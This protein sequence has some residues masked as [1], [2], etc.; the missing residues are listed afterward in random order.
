M[1][2]RF[3]AMLLGVVMCGFGVY[4]FIDRTSPGVQDVIDVL[5]WLAAAIAL[6]D[7]L[8][9]PLVLAVGLL[10]ARLT[11]LSGALRGGLL[12]AA[13]LTL[14]ALPMMLRE[15]KTANPTVLPLDYVT[16]WVA[17]IAVTVVVTAGVAWVGHRRTREARRLEEM[18]PST[19]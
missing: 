12:C 19:R 4:Q 10:I 5:V 2:L 9:V 15:G 6:H 16:N 3:S 14:V 11:R 7:G 1:L 17:T 13:C 18:A 8:L